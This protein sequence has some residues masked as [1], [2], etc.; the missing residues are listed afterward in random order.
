MGRDRRKVASEWAQDLG[1]SFKDFTDI[2]RARI[3]AS[4]QIKV[5]GVASII[6]AFF[7]GAGFSVA[8]GTDVRSHYPMVVIPF[9]GLWKTR[10]RSF[11]I[12][13]LASSFSALM[14]YLMM[15]LNWHWGTTWG[16]TTYYGSFS[17]TRKWRGE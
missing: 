8:I 7:A 3:K 13:I 2:K 10:R 12:I 5:I 17:R 15:A 11:L 9:A 4:L 6:A 1:V 16:D 14:G